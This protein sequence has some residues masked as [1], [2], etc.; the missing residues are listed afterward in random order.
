[1]SVGRA[2]PVQAPAKNQ[3]GS[4]GSQRAH[5]RVE[6]GAV[7]EPVPPPLPS[8]PTERAALFATID[9]GIAEAKAGLLV[10]WEDLD[11]QICKKFGLP[12]A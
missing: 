9:R 2:L 8:D 6:D 7:K 4:V 10:D 1:M 5:K 3:A 11:A 12:P